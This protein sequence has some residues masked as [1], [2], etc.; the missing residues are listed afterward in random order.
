MS[1]KTYVFGEGSN[2][3]VLSLLGPLMQ[4]KGID[5]NVLLAMKNNSGFGGE[6]GWFIWI[7]FLVLLGGWGNG[8][9]GRNGGFLANELNNDFGR[10]W[11]LQAIDGNGDAIQQ[12]ATTLHCDVNRIQNAINGVQSSIQ[13]VSSQVGLSSSQII[14]AIQSG[15]NAIAS[16]LASCCCDVKTGI[17]RG[18]ASVNENTF[19]QTCDIEKAI[20]GSTSAITARIDAME[21]TNLLDK[22]DK[23]REEKSTLANQL[24]QEHQSLALMQNTASELAP[25]TASINALHSEIDSIKCKLPTTVTANYNPYTVVPNC[26]YTLYNCGYNGW[27][28]NSLWG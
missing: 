10:N 8:F 9:G 6:G 7:L 12:L 18:F 16:Q 19:R 23:L 13:T 3:G 28:G 15:N 2:S 17:E 20:A 27:T 14:N 21:K 5:P 24:S 25:I 26:A 1:E 4:Q 22:I 11:L